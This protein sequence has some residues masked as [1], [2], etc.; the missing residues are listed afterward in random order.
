VP[1]AV[2]VLPDCVSMWLRFTELNGMLLSAL[3]HKMLVT[4]WR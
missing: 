4:Y 1:L 3:E 2:V